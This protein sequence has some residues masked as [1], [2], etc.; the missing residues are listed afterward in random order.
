MGRGIVGTVRLAPAFRDFWRFVDVSRIGYHVVK[1]MFKLQL[2]TM[3][4]L[5]VRP[6]RRTFEDG[7]TSSAGSESAKISLV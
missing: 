2:R 4:K 1:G 3:V 5:M 7:S 6:G